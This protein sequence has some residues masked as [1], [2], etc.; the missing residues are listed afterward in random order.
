MICETI[1]E[2]AYEE[3]AIHECY[4][5]IRLFWDTVQKF[6]SGVIMLNNVAADTAVLTILNAFFEI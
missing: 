6:Y 3:G 4:V 2:A 1:C 5:G